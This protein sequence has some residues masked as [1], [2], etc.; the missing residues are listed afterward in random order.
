MFHAAKLYGISIT[1]AEYLDAAEINRGFIFSAA[2][3]M[4]DAD[5]APSNPQSTSLRNVISTH[6]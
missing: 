1:E 2:E 5:A 3:S 6:G 4:A